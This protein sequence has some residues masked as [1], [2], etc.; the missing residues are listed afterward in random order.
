MDALVEARG[1]WKRL[2]SRWVLRDVMLSLRR[3]EI[4]FITGSNGSGKTTL[5]RILAGLVKPS[6]GSVVYL[7]RGGRRCIGYSGHNPMLYDVMTVRENID[8]YAML[9]GV[10]SDGIKSNPAWEGLKLDNVAERR[11]SEL[12]YGW[13]KRADIMRAI[14]HG[15][16]I[17]LFDEPFTGLD[18][19][20]SSSLGEVIRWL[21]SRRSGIVLTSPRP[22][23]EYL[24]LA[25]RVYEIVNGE[26]RIAC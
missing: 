20:A 6:R 2:G 3:G 5:L 17:V 18:P 23:R 12:S 16:E 7:C 11:I 19:E 25:H 1:L 8:Y 26:L 15:P 9:Y 21:A 14:L 24:D 22:D 4:L 13:R 10:D